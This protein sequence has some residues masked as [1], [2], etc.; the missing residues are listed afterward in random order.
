M[1][2]NHSMKERMARQLATCGITLQV[3][4][5]IYPLDRVN[6]FLHL[7]CGPRIHDIDWTVMPPQLLHCRGHH[8]DGFLRNVDMLKG[9]PIHLDNCD[10]C[11]PLLCILCAI[12][13]F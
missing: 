2:F 4:G 7:W 3:E 8:L 10:E 12:K 13:D 6:D 5:R 9:L 1:L 11:M